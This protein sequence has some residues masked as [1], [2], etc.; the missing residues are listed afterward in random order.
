M[1]TMSLAQH[2]EQKDGRGDSRVS[3]VP[4]QGALLAFYDTS[5]SFKLPRRTGIQSVRALCES[6]SLLP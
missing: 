5:G 4:G 3:T 1:Y 2:R 6:G